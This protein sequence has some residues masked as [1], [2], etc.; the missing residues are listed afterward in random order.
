MN[1]E[2]LSIASNGR[3]AGLGGRE[4]CSLGE[5]D[6]PLLNETLGGNS[7]S[8]PVCLHHCS[9]ENSLDGGLELIEYLR[10]LCMYENRRQRIQ[11][12][13]CKYM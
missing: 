6:G 8:T 13:T 11:L 9:E 4:G 10:N 1:I 5:R 3:P 7:L 2:I 12:Y